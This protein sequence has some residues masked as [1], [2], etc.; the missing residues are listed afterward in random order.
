MIFLL[1]AVTKEKRKE[2]V[3][4]FAELQASLDATMSQ[5]LGF[6]VGDGVARFLFN[7]AGYLGAGD[8]DV[9]NNIAGDVYIYLD[10]ALAFTYDRFR[11]SCK[12]LLGRYYIPVDKRLLEPGVLERLIYDI[13]YYA[14][15]NYV[16]VMYDE[17]MAKRDVLRIISFI[18]VVRGFNNALL[19]VFDIGSLTE[20]VMSYIQRLTFRVFEVRES[21]IKRA[22]ESLAKTLGLS[23]REKQVLY[24]LWH[25]RCVHTHGGQLTSSGVSVGEVVSFMRSITLKSL[26]S[27]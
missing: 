23:Q 12:G 15:W 6:E 1:N 13:L 20:R 17:N 11:S 2:I 19:Y 27:L 3:K 10:F 25:M 24:E 22:L 18:D 7:M 14:H 16:V 9:G 4:V 26:I 21:S 8:V 5:S